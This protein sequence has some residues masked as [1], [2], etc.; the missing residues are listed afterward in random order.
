MNLGARNQNFHVLNE[1]EVEIKTN[2]GMLVRNTAV[3]NRKGFLILN[4]IQ[5]LKFEFQNFRCTGMLPES[6]AVLAIS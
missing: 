4:E 3:F 5:I 6:I 2:T 1:E